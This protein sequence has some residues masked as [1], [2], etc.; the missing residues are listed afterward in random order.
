MNHLKVGIIGAA[1]L[2]PFVACAM[3]DCDPRTLPEKEVWKLGNE[4][5]DRFRTT[6]EKKDEWAY[7]TLIR[8]DR[9]DFCDFGYDASMKK[10]DWPEDGIHFSMNTDKDFRI[11]E[12]QV[13]AY[14][15][16]PDWTVTYKTLFEEDKRKALN[17]I[18]TAAQI[19]EKLAN[20]DFRRNPRSQ[21]CVV[22]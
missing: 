9:S 20:E 10:R 15:R 2:W 16:N 3:L 11:T 19:I 13:W 14:K 22:S 12:I 21:E 8:V 17:E 1:F 7:F 6:Y 18:K 5:Y 4:T